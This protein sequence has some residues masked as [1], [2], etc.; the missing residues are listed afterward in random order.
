MADQSAQD[1]NLPASAKKLKKARDD[2]QV[3]RSRDL[4]H[5]TAMTAGGFMLAM[6]TPT[7]V[8]WLQHM[9]R[10]ALSFDAGMVRNPAAM[11]EALADLAIKMVLVIAPMGVVMMLVAVASGA[12]AGGLVFSLK[13]IAPK[14]ERI[15]PLAGMGRLF[16]WQHASD[17]LKSSVLA[18]ILGGVGA[19]VMKDR[20]ANYVNIMSVPLPSA[21]SY[22]GNLLLGGL[23][24]PLLALAVFAAVDLP[25]QRH[26]HM[27]RLKMTREEAKQEFKQAEGNAEVKGRMRQI[28]REMAKSRMMAAVPLADL[29]VMNPTHYAVALKYDEKA[30]AAPRVVAK[31]AD[32]LALRIRDLAKG[33]KVPVLESPMLARALYA[34][35]EVDRE[36]PAALFAAVAQVLAY[37]YQLRAA[38]AG[39]APMP[40]AQPDPHVPV[41]LD[42]H[43]K[44]AAQADDSIP[45]E[46][47]A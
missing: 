20:M 6:L 16:S 15:S 33:S 39:K 44:A 26:L 30:M 43:H 35:S 19:L 10:K 9:L 17:A 1:R 2:G 4:G 11:G 24:F 7:A 14:F 27:R 18:L 36:I 46:R 5:F 38:M 8:D 3:V 13:P 22:A 45:T 41:D 23:M 28:M 29:V 25:L 12:M 31:G 37:V 34:H 42:P 40:D 21:I 32:L 47:D